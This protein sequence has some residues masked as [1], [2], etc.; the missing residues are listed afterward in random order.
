MTTTHPRLDTSLPV[1]QEPGSSGGGSGKK[2]QLM[3]ELASLTSFGHQW[4][5]EDDVYADGTSAMQRE[6]GVDVDGGSSGGAKVDDM[7]RSQLRLAASRMEF[8]GEERYQGRK[9]SRRRMDDDDD[10]DNDDDGKCEGC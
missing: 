5:P 2:K 10:D 9:V 4:D 3:K 6:E 7:P 8:D 1:K